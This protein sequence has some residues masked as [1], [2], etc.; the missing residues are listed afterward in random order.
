MKIELEGLRPKAWVLDSTKGTK[1]TL[2]F[3]VFG[4]SLGLLES[5]H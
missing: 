1:K 4:N 2:Y 3:L 5:D